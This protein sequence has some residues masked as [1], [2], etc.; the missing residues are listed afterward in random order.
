MTGRKPSLYAVLAKRPR[1]APTS[2]DAI[3]EL[4]LYSRLSAYFDVF[5]NNE[6]FS[7]EKQE[8]GDPDQ[9]GPARDYDFYYTRNNPE[10]TMS[11]K[12]KRI[13]FAY[14][15]HEE[16][17]SEVDYLF[18]P[19]QSWKTHLQ[20]RG[21]DSVG[22]IK[23]AYDG[24]IPKI[25]CPIVNVSQ[26]FDDFFVT[27]RP[28]EKLLQNLRFRSSN[29]S[30]F[31]YYGNLHKDYYPLTAFRGLES[32]F[33]RDPHKR[34]TTV[35][36]GRFRR[37][38]HVAFRNT[39]YMGNLDYRE[40]PAMLDISTCVLTNETLLNHCLGSYKVIDA[41]SRDVP[42]M[43]K[44]Y[45]VFVEQLGADY[46]CYYETEDEACEIASKLVTDQDF[47]QSVCDS[48]ADRKHLYTRESAIERLGA[49][50]REAGLIS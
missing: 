1:I 3:N 8:I 35:L 41:M 21:E 31:G 18:V 16:L 7:E 26:A 14:P 46:P 22:K 19:T 12:G 37:D 25:S 20:Q 29:G 36:A 38:S 48:I 39:M 4:R 33:L 10:L 9:I 43:C 5:Y 23:I 30:V 32:A 49:Q 28:N 50:L 40:M 45:D 15:Y 44:P 47:R 34:A 2:G 13:A 6:P 24:T 11:I 27:N 42:V 17:F